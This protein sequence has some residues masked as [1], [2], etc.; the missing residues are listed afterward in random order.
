MVIPDEMDVLSQLFDA[1]YYDLSQSPPSRSSTKSHQAALASGLDDVFGMAFSSMATKHGNYWGDDLMVDPILGQADEFWDC[2]PSLGGGNHE[3]TE[4]EQHQRSDVF[5]ADEF[6][7]G[8]QNWEDTL[9][10]NANGTSLP[11]YLLAGST[12]SP[13]P[14]DYDQRSANM[15]FKELIKQEPYSPTQ[16]DSFGLENQTEPFSSSLGQDFQAAAPDSQGL[17]FFRFII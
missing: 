17:N 16:A 1:G 5:T 10:Q 3:D 15:S 2:L 7:A 11:E 4:L 14:M 9:V 13:I 8:V 12:R 6:A